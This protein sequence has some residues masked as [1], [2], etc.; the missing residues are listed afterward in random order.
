MSLN[1]AVLSPKEAIEFILETFTKPQTRLHRPLLHG[2]QGVGKSSILRE[3]AR[4]MEADLYDFRLVQVETTDIRGLTIVDPIA[5][6]TKHMR[7]EFLPAYSHDGN[8]KKAIIFLDEIL[9]ADDR[10]RKAAFELI[11]D[12]RVGPHLMGKNVY[13]AGAGNSAEDGNNV[14]ELDAATADR[15]LH[16]KIM[17][18]ID[19]F[20]EF[21]IENN[22]HPLI[23]AFIRNHPGCFLQ[24]E[25]DIQNANVARPSPRSLERC[26]ESLY[27]E[28]SKDLFRDAAL[29]GWLGDYA[30]GLL[31]DDLNDEAARFD[32]MKLLSAEPEKREY[33]TS[34]FGIYSLAHS[35][36]AYAES[37]EKL[38]IALEVMMALPNYPDV[39]VV[40][41]KTSFFFAIEKKM[42]DWKLVAKYATDSRVKPF[43]ERTD[44]IINA[45]DR[46]HAERE[47]TPL[48]ELQ[49]A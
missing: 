38:D 49:A 7:P 10:L 46:A 25:A 12:N 48:A 18:T 11:L 21:G 27:A 32:L 43:L 9:A 34:Q 35:L 28:Y 4:R 40:E 20:V 16:I 33:P 45:A 41:C 15:F 37:P 23:L 19:G 22:L 14:Y 26:S 1:F 8:A 6:T 30:G 29:R 44:E 36:A 39:P 17:P 24:S 42:W 13:L 5:G 31:I 47:N 3:V 2:I